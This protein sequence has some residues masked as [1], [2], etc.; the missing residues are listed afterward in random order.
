MNTDYYQ[1]TGLFALI[2]S[3]TF[4]FGF[5]HPTLA[6]SMN[7]VRGA[8]Y[9]GHVLVPAHDNFF[10]SIPPTQ[11]MRSALR[12]IGYRPLVSPAY[13]PLSEQARSAVAEREAFQSHVAYGPLF[14]LR[15]VIQP[16]TIRHG[17]GGN[18]G[19]IVATAYSSTPDQTDDDPC[20]TANGYNVCSN[21]REDV[22]AANFLPFGTRVR[23]PD[24][25]GSRVFVVQDRMHPRFSNRVDIWM[26]TRSAAKNFGVKHLRM[27]IIKDQLA[28]K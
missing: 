11:R 23:F 2:L 6:L 17:V 14:P 13:T 15:R 10:H 16:R 3:I 27:E 22:I 28:M 21:G 12:V 9:T 7:A 24:T 19:T 8:F 25:F 1:K 20:T 26:K 4:T 18:I 5:P